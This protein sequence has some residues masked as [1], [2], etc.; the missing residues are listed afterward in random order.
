[1]RIVYI[2]P[3]VG[4]TFYCQNCIKNMDLIN[5]L[6]KKGHDVLFVPMYLPS[7]EEESLKIRPPVFFGAISV[8][9]REKL[10]FLRKLPLFLTS[11]MDARWLL[12]LISKRTGATNPVG[13]EEMTLSVLK[14]EEGGH[15]LELERLIKWLK[16]DIKPD[17]VQLSTVLLIGIATKIKKELGVPVFSVVQDEDIW[18][19]KMPSPYPEKCWEVIRKG[20][21]KI[22]ALISASSYYAG[23][24][25]NRAGIS[26]EKIHILPTGIDMSRYRKHT[27]ATKTPCIG[28]LSRMSDIMGLDILIES[29]IRLKSEKGLESLRLK[30]Y[31]G[32]APQDRK[33]VNSLREKLENA[34]VS[35]FVELETELRSGFEEQ[36]FDGL[37]VLCVPVPQGE[38]FGI[39]LLE[40]MAS[41]IPVVQPEKGGYPEIIKET[42]GGITYKDNTPEGLAK[43]LKSLLLNHDRLIELSNNGFNS[44]TEKYSIEKTSDELLSVYSKYR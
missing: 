14:G 5:E 35:D 25:K 44:V 22:D 18:I 34:G 16:E 37:S 21:E 7:I 10:P 11:W 41:G 23:F 19:D 28:F 3:G 33:F 20:S 4:D 8:Y 1:M 42:G 9:L 17:V 6:K 13:L 2:L 39:F 31:G 12:K 29:Y 26:E 32:I 15:S 27:P 43:V 40:A 30:V 24:A 38:A 36:F